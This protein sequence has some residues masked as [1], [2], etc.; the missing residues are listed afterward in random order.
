[1]TAPEAVN[2]TTEN[3]PS[4]KELNFRM[5]EAKFEKQLAQERAARLE[6]ERIAQEAQNRKAPIEEDDDSEPYVDNKKLNKKLQHFGEQTK[7][8][9]QAEIQDAVQKAIY[10]ERK[11]S[12]IKN[13]PDFYEVLQHAEKFAQ[14]DP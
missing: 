7:K 8:Q 10:E 3:K 2:Q 4:D 12:W 14:K 11:S 9:T 1:M 5:L 13:N 6:A